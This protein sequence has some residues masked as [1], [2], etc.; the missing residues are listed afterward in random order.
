MPIPTAY[1]G[2]GELLVLRIQRWMV[3]ASLL[4]TCL[5]ALE[6]LSPLVTDA[7][8][9]PAPPRRMW[10]VPAARV[11]VCSTP[12]YRRVGMGISLM[13]ERAATAGWR[14][15][16]SDAARVFL[17]KQGW[18]ERQHESRPRLPPFLVLCSLPPPTAHLPA[19]P[20]AGTRIVVVAFPPLVLP[21]PPTVTAVT[22]IATTYLSMNSA[23]YC[24]TEVGREAC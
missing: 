2:T 15:A 9:A 11:A 1:G 10:L 12:S 6:P 7:K 16:L 14:G 23:A 8:T 5:D 21:L 22:Q 13:L 24:S 20:P 19:A 3:P 4:G 17:G 18:A